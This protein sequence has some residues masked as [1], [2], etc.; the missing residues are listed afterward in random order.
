MLTATKFLAFALLALKLAVD[1]QGRSPCS[2]CRVTECED[3]AAVQERCPDLPLVAN[4]CACCK[5]CPKKIGEVCGGAYAYLGTCEYD[6][7]I[8]CTANSSEYL[9]GVNVSGICTSECVK[10]RQ[11]SADTISNCAVFF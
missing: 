2:F 9:R 6:R 4:P 7:N 5:E 3:E 1:V 10:L 8:F 11:L